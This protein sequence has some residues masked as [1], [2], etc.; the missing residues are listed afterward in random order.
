MSHGQPTPASAEEIEDWVRAG[1]CI[2]DTARPD[3]RARAL[4]GVA[5]AFAESV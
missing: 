4:Y 1:R 2:A 5:V 3:V